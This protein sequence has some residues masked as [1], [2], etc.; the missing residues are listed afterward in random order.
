MPPYVRPIVAAGR[1]TGLLSLFLAC[2]PAPGKTASPAVT[3]PLYATVP[4]DR[5]PS[6]DGQWLM[7]GRDYANT[8]FSG[9][10]EITAD[11][12]ARLRVAWTFST[13]VLRGQ[14]AAPI[15]AGRTMYLVTPYPN[16]LHALDLERRGELRWTYAPRPA[17]A[18][19]GVACCD[20]VNRGA[21]YADGRLFYN[22]LDNQTVAVDAASG[23]ELWRTK[24][25]D[26][27]TGE[28]MTMAPIVVKGKVLVGNSGGEFGV[29]GWIKGLDAGTGE[30]SWTAYST[31]P[32]DDVKIGPE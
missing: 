20:V 26:I 21:A 2:S 29:R 32:D 31:G 28:S 25:G 24:L 7:A 11:N 27:N 10:T 6:D 16:L 15:V 9:L 5:T 13:G 14:E 8:R 12:V 17:P 22:T 18:A 3:V 19:Q 1:A 4:A 30:V 23:R